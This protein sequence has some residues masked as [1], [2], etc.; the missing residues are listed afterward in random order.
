MTDSVSSSYTAKIHNL[1]YQSDTFTVAEAKPAATLV[2]KLMEDPAFQTIFLKLGGQTPQEL[3]V[4]V[5]RNE[6]YIKLN[7]IDGEYIAISDQISDDPD[8]LKWNNIKRIAHLALDAMKK[9]S[10]DLLSTPTSLARSQSFASTASNLSVTAEVDTFDAKDDD[11]GSV[12]SIGAQVVDS[13]TDFLQ[14]QVQSLSAE[15]NSLRAKHLK[16]KEDTLAIIDQMTT[17]FEAAASNKLNQ[18]ER[19]IERLKTALRDA[20]ATH[21]AHKGELL[22]QIDKGKDTVKSV[23]NKNKATLET[24]EKLQA[25]LTTSEAEHQAQLEALKAALKHKTRDHGIADSN[26]RF[27]QKEAATLRAQVLDLEKR[28]EGEEK[29]KAWVIRLQNQLLSA[30]WKIEELEG[31]LASSEVKFKTYYEEIQKIRAGK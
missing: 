2:K 13:E 19:E 1:H 20:S 7:P 6:V 27:F 15:L 16:A 3:R 24:L 9:R 30:T 4:R 18:A 12:F 11:A 22:R 10:S 17:E 26:I 25:A 14:T 31:K 23:V 29:N 28:L 8:K 21:Q 5:R